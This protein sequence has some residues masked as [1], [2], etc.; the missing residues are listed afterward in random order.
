[1]DNI[2]KKEETARL[3]FEVSRMLKQCMRKSFESSELTMPQS[4]IAF[5]L[6]K[7]GKMK[8]S[9]LS[10]RV[11]LSNSTVSGIIDRLEKQ[12]YV[13]R[14]RSAEDRRTVYVNV[15]N[16]FEEAHKGFH[17][18]MVKNFEDML[19]YGTSEQ[20]DK[21]NEGLVTLKTILLKGLEDSKDK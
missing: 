5:T 3:F 7:N 20:M 4:V 9:D 16:K 14:V 8:I 2:N 17:K 10:D 21:I 19:I 12:G 15:T 18:N 1:M 11:N 6:I 13:E